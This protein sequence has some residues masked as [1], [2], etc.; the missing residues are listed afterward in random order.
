MLHLTLSESQGKSNL[1]NLDRKRIIKRRRGNLSKKSDS[2]RVG[3]NLNRKFQL[4]QH[5]IIQNLKNKKVC[6]NV[7]ALEE[8]ARAPHNTSQYLAST[9]YELI[10]RPFLNFNHEL[11]Y[12]IPSLQNKEW[13]V[14]NT[15]AYNEN[16]D[17][18]DVFLVGGSMVGFQNET[19]L[20]QLLNP[21]FAMNE[22]SR[23]V[24]TEISEMSS[25]KRENNVQYFS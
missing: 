11:A 1:T 13:E 25:P 17:E 9:H 8:G 24:E 23:S 15:G 21:N 18:D 14:G 22:D 19:L 3:C 7:G 4:K 5:R 2:L 10:G 6:L 20:E 12:I 16:T